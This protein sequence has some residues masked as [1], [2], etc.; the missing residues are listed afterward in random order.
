LTRTAQAAIGKGKTLVVIQLSGGNDALNTLVP[1]TNGAYYAARPSIAIGKKDVLTLSSEVGFNPA[2][3][4][5][6]NLWDNGELALKAWQ[7]GTPPT[8]RLERPMVGS[9]RLLRSTATRSAPRI[10]ATLHLWR[11]VVRT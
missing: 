6:M 3:K 7:S 4:P 2:L 11:C 8:L 5:F 10:L 1:Y 9:V